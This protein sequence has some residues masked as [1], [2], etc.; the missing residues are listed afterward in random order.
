[1]TVEKM[2][3]RWDAFLDELRVEGAAAGE[4]AAGRSPWLARWRRSRV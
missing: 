1:M 2:D 4:M 3:Q